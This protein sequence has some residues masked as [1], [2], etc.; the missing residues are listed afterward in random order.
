MAETNADQDQK[1]K[2]VAIEEYESTRA[3]LEKVRQKAKEAGEKLKT[4]EDERENAKISAM[5]EKEDWKKLAELREQEATE[6]KK[7]LD[8]TGKA[9]TEY[10]KKAEIRAQ[11]MKAGI[12]ESA[13]DDLDLLQFSEVN[14]ETTSTGRINVLGADKAVERIKATRPFWFEDKK[15]PAIDTTN[16]KVSKGQKLNMKDILKLQKEGKTEEYQAAVMKLKRGG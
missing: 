4:M 1:P 8:T 5:K 7:R 11:A 14:V 6:L 2:H 3:E 9:T 10:F 12:R 16:P 15:A 13:L